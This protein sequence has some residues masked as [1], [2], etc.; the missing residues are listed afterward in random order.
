MGEGRGNWEG[1]RLGF[2][3]CSIGDES[4]FK[5]FTVGVCE[6]DGALRFNSAI[7]AGAVARL[8]PHD[9][10][11][12]LDV[13]TVFASCAGVDAVIADDFNALMRRRRG[14][15]TLRSGSSQGEERGNDDLRATQ[16]LTFSIKL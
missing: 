2:V 4:E 3:S 16:K 7:R 15:V 14:A 11:S 6:S 8:G 9:A 5:K 10:V 1:R 13:K 12:G